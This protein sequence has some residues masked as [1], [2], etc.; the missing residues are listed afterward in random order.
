MGQEDTA[1]NRTS[2]ISNEHKFRS[3]I[4]I[5]V[6]PHES[7]S[8]DNIVLNEEIIRRGCIRHRPKHEY[9]KQRPELNHTYR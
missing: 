7:R 2:K 6:Y 4:H 3:N 8:K 5:L 9:E 1:E